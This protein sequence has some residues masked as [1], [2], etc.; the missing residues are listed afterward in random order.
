MSNKA[1]RFFGPVRNHTGYGNAVGNFALA[2]SKSS[3]DTKFCFS[4]KDTKSNKDLISRLKVY[5][6][7]CGIDFYIH[8]PPWDRHKSSNYKIGYFY[9]EADR[10]P[11]FWIKKINSVNELWVPCNLVRKACI[12]A[13]FKGPIEVLPTPIEQWESPERVL[14]PSPHD[15]G[16]CISDNIFKFYSIFQWHHRKGPDI[17]LKTYWDEFGINDNVVLILKVNP[18]SKSSVSAIKN[19]IYNI[20]RSM[21]RKYYAPVYIIDNIVSVEKIRAIHDLCHA[22]V[23]PH[24]GEGWGLPIHDAMY[25][26][27]NVIVT[28]FGGITEFLSNRN[29]NIITHHIVPVTNMDWSP[30]IYNRSQ[31]WAK[32][33]KISLSSQMR[34]VYDKYNSKTMC[35]KR[36]KAR[37][38]ALSMSI[39]S[40]SKKIEKLLRRGRS[41]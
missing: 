10:L 39:D 29:S 24:R 14:I 17:L 18:L 1:V 2:F 15:E 41:V 22:Y 6:G 32:P 8:P 33:S 12:S 5:N 28:K 37:E 20:K 21:K 4:E 35:L 13:G 19:D 31:K 34:E 26:G 7:S 30:Y 11:S 36:E 23:S 38:L 25:S 9:W 3:I 16:L 40:V 27:N